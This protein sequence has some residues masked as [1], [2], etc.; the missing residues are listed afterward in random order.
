MEEHY[1]PEALEK[2]LQDQETKFI[3]TQLSE[4]MQKLE[5]FLPTVGK[6]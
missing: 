5:D 3:H 1:T 4:E 2:M 6:N